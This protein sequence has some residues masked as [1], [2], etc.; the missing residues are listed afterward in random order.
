MPNRNVPDLS[1]LKADDLVKVMKESN[2]E[3]IK[4]SREFVATFMDRAND[5]SAIDAANIG[6]I[7]DLMGA[8]ARRGDGGCGSLSG[9]CC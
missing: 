8:L 9:G 1:H 4:K 6:K 5:I 3:E 2:A 7:T